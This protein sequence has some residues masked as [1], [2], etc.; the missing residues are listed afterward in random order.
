M[1]TSLDHHP[2]PDD[3]HPNDNLTADL[4]N[5]Y[6]DYQ[7]CG[8]ATVPDFIEFQAAEMISKVLYP[9]LL[10]LGV[11]GNGL[12]LFVHR[13]LSQ[14]AWSSCLYLAVLSVV[15]MIVLIIRCGGTWFLEEVS[16][17][18][19]VCRGEGVVVSSQSERLVLLSLLSVVEMIVLILRCGG[20]WFLEVAGLNPSRKIMNSSDAMCKT[21]LFVLNVLLQM[22]PWLMVALSVELVISTRYP[23]KTYHLCTTERARATVLLITILLVCLN[24]NFFW[25]WGLGIGEEC[26]YIELFSIEF[27]NVIWPSI[28]TTVKHVLPLIAVTVAFLLSVLSL[29]KAGRSGA[30]SYE[31]ILKKYF[32]DL[33][34]LQQLKHVALITVLFFIVVKT[35]TFVVELLNAL[36]SRGVIMVPCEE[37]AQFRARFKLV[38]TLRDA[39]MYSFHSLKFFVY[40][41]L[42]ASFRQK[43]FSLLRKLFCCA[44]AE[45]GSERKTRAVQNNEDNN[46]QFQQIEDH[47][48]LDGN[49]RRISAGLQD[50]NGH[51]TVLNKTTHV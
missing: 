30:P 39:V 33:Q 11:V 35:F 34:A 8:L 44:K 49:S 2:Y 20:T 29:F 10:I 18:L 37:Y 43:V 1:S 28:E 25:T 5:I 12:S 6:Y 32:L 13:H 51:S 31:P 42:C 15:E 26:M 24:L 48:G 14:N 23:L 21:Y 16:L 17:V 4:F 38:Q 36:E 3:H 19:V 27:L 7:D 45:G 9:G 41:A 40:F 46:K 22:W 47:V 50:I